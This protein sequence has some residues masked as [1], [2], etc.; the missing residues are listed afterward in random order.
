MLQI[1][2]QIITL[3]NC[4]HFC[5]LNPSLQL[6]DFKIK[7]SLASILYF[8]LRLLCPDMLMVILFEKNERAIEICLYK[9]CNK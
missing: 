6:E 8:K 1:Y 4:K 9:F 7:A 3:V 2:R 5:T